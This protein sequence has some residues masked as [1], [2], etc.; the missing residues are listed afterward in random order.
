MKRIILF[1]FPALFSIAC[2][3]QGMY[4]FEG[5]LGKTM[6]YT[7]HLV[8]ELKAYVTGSITRHIY[9]GGGVSM[10]RYSFL[11]ASNVAPIAAN[12]G[13]TINIR[14]KSSYLF[15]SPKVDIGIGYYQYLHLNLSAGAGV[16]MGGSQWTNRYQQIFTTPSSL[17]FRSDT[18]GY[19]TTASMPTLVFRYGAGLSERIPT[20]GYWN[21]IL[22]EDF[23]YLPRS[24]DKNFDGLKSNYISF[25]VGV[26]HKYP[27]VMMED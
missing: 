26:M 14:N 11:Y 1:F 27:M 12:Y 16:F 25:S 17:S 22:S 3:S 8:P 15:F 5:G 4:G 7:S 24:F 21:I 20:H 9:V 6:S 23:G 19:N 2:Y 10:E 18:A 13:Q